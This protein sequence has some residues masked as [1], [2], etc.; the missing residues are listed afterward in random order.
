[1]CFSCQGNSKILKKTGSWRFEPPLDVAVEFYY[2]KEDIPEDTLKNKAIQI[3]RDLLKSYSK[4]EI[5][6]CY[7][8]RLAK[9][10]ASEKFK[11]EVA[12]GAVGLDDRIFWDAEAKVMGGALLQMTKEKPEGEWHFTPKMERK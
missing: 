6:I 7:D 1:M 8:R 11:E 4:V 2:I 5:Y 12:K 9:K 3:G 10:V